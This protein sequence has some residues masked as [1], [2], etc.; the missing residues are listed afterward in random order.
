MSSGVE[1]SRGSTGSIRMG[2]FDFAALR[3]G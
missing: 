3:S 1:K 2:S